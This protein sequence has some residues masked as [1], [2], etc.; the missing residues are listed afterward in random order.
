RTKRINIP[1][2]V[3]LSHEIMVYSKDYNKKRVPKHIAP[4]AIEMAA[5]WA[6]LTRIDAPKEELTGA[7]TKMQ[8]LRLY[9]GEHIPKYTED[10]VKKL[11]E[12]SE[13]EGLDGISPRFIQNAIYEAIT[14]INE[15]C[16]NAFMILSK[17][18]NDLKTST[19]VNSA[20]EK[21]NYRELLG[22]VEKE[23]EDIIKDEI[24]RVISSDA[25][26]L[27]ELYQKYILNLKAFMQKETMV[28]N[29]TGRDKP[30]DE[31]FMRSIEEK[32][33]VDEADK[34][35]FRTTIMQYIACCKIDDKKFDFRSNV[36]LR[37]GL[38]KKLFED[39]KESINFQQVLLNEEDAEEELKINKIADRLIKDFGY[40]NVCAKNTL[41]LVASIFAKGDVE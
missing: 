2:N 23:Y 22:N 33:P 18:K 20:E 6:V 21:T 24:Q 40:C 17:L 19:L 15:P 31:R 9:D 35:S 39:K 28:D 14:S 25:T 34:E 30:A 4:H 41:E 29:L 37:K 5:M 32:V 10:F 7:L 27:D 16:V 26:E 1:Y 3:K 8:K 36:E 12:D 38:E 13:R 11:K